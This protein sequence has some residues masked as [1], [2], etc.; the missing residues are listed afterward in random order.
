MLK[1]YKMGIGGII[2]CYIGGTVRFFY[3]NSI[4]KLGLTSRKHYSFKEYINGP[5]DPED[6][7]FDTIGHEFINKV[8]GFITIVII[9]AIIIQL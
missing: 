7:I 4:R 9:W 8:V 2:F 6:I 1:K 3:G 5:N